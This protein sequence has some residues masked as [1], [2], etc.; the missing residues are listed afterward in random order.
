MT[1]I[2]IRSNINPDQ[3]S[4]FFCCPFTIPAKYYP[5]VF[6]LIF[7]LFF[8]ILWHFV[9]GLLVG[10]LHVYEYNRFLKVGE[11]FVIQHENSI[12]LAWL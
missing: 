11:N 2:V 6:L 8:G 10:Y 1:E 4:R 12:F 7:S 3:P 5:W 9:V